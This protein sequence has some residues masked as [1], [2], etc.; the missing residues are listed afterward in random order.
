MKYLLLDTRKRPIG[1]LVSDKSFAVGDTFQ[2]EGSGQGAG[3]YAG[4]Y[5]VVGL[6][7]FTQRSHA[8]SLTVMPVHPPAKA[9]VE[10]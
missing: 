10:V 5:T 7:W 8:Q 6:N 4:L 1:T 9:V 3:A 2:S